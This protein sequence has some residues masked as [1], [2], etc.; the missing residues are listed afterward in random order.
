VISFSE[1]EQFLQMPST[2]RKKEPQLRYPYR[3]GK[4][5]SKKASL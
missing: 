3:Q 2:T 4:S 1:P 5:Q